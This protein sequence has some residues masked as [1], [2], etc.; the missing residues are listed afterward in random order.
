MIAAHML[1]L[2]G[3]ASD[4]DAGR[5]MSLQAIQSGSAVAKFREWIEAQGGDLRVIDDE[6]LLPRA[7][8]VRVV[9]APRRGYL[10]A[11]DAMEVGLTCV[12]LGGGRR[13]KGDTIDHSVGI[14]V[15]LKVGDQVASGRPLFTVYARNEADLQQAVDRLMAACEWSEGPV[16]PLP[17]FYEVIPG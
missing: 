2:G 6:S 9:G 3:V 17:L 15:H 16:E 12:E 7:D 11:L 4:A 10:A 13:E 5:D 8:C 14:V 1:V